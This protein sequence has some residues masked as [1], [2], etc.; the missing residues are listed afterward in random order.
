M[1]YEN[2]IEKLITIVTELNA[3]ECS[4]NCVTDMNTFNWDELC[5]KGISLFKQLKN[6]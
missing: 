2:I 5:D 6:I 1:N 4:G 3:R